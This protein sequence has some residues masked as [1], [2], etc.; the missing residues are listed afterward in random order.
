MYKIIIQINVKIQMG[1]VKEGRVCGIMNFY[2][3]GIWLMQEDQ[4][5]LP[6]RKDYHAETEKE[7]D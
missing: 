3:R 7:K 5:R 6:W 2:K 4:G 1:E